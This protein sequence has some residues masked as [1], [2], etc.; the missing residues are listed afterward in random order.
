MNF[1]AHFVKI[2]M[3]LVSAFIVTSLIFLIGTF[4]LAERSATSD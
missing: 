1:W 4:I 3:S 2:C